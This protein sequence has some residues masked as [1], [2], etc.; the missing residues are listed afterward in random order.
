MMEKF[1]EGRSSSF[2]YFTHDKRFMVKTVSSGERKVVTDML[3]DYANHLAEYPDTF[4]NKIYGL[5]GIQLHNGEKIK[6]FIVMESVMWTSNS[7]THRFDLKGSWVDRKAYKKGKE[8]ELHEQHEAGK[9]EELMKDEDLKEIGFH[10]YVS[11]AE[12]LR[13]LEQIKQDINLFAKQNVMD[14]SLL[15]AI[16]QRTPKDDLVDYADF[17]KF[18]YTKKE[19]FKLNQDS[20]WRTINYSQDEIKVMQRILALARAQLSNKLEELDALCEKHERNTRKAWASGQIDQQV[21][22]ESV[23]K[24]VPDLLKTASEEELLCVPFQRG[25]H[26]QTTDGYIPAHRRCEGGTIKP[27]Q[28]TDAPNANL[29]YYIG[30]IDITQEWD[31]KKAGEN[32]AKGRLL[33]KGTHGISAVEPQQYC[34]RYLK[35]MEDL[36]V[37]VDTETEQMESVKLTMSSHTDGQEANGA[38]HNNAPSHASLV[39]KITDDSDTLQATFV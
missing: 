30:I 8:K 28:P 17:K 21:F 15:L 2:F 14:Y 4:I 7:I 10:I 16:H 18:L 32:F 36:I 22:I 20:T 29:I 5:H 23:K 1:S 19:T 34:E 12:R 6:Y 35:A 3:Q 24:I 9:V 11:E 38:N 26:I 33:C 27:R 13:M 25:K 39:Q 31:S 37:A